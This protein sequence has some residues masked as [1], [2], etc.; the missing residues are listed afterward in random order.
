MKLYEVIF[1]GTGGKTDNDSDTMFLVRAED[2]RSALAEARSNCSPDMV[3]V[4]VHEIGHDLTKHPEDA[5]RILR[6]P[7][8]AHSDNYG[9]K[10]WYRKI[11]NADDTDEWDEKSYGEIPYS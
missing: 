4:V 2:F 1:L 10:A 8:F 5:P 6:G 9:W 11:K 3:P 7:Y